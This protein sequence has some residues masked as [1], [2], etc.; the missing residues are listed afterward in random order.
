VTVGDGTG[1]DAAVPGY[2][3]SGKTGT[4]RKHTTGGYFDDRHQSVFIGMVPAENPRLVGLVMIDEP[5]GKQY[6]GGQV[7]GPVFSNV[8]RSAVRQLQLAPDGTP[9]TNT[10]AAS[11]RVPRT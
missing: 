9:L 3:V 1:V 5:K 11:P 8:M 2:R 7:A 6:Y 4:V 10:A